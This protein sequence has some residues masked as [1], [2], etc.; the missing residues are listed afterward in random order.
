MNV[1]LWVLQV[2]L[3]AMFAMAGVMK[4]LQP[5]EKLAGNLPW[6]QD[7][8]AGTVRFIGAVEFLAALGLILPAATGIAPILTPLAATGLVIVMALAIVVHV[9]RK[10][11]AAIGFNVILLVVA[12]VVAWGRFGPYAF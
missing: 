12:A 9:R 2:V 7:F 6:V 1:F 10:E 3:A 11:P 5:K 8:S 4:T